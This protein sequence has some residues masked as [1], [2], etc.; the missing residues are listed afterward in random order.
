[1][2]EPIQIYHAEVLDHREVAPEHYVMTL[3]APQVAAQARPGQFV[4][5]R[6]LGGCDPLL[7][8]AYSVYHADTT[9]GSVEVLYRVVGRG[10]SRLRLN[11]R[12][13]RV[14]VWGPLG[15]AFTP[16]HG[17]RAVLVGGGV[18]IPPLAFWAHRLAALFPTI[19]RVALIGA[20]TREFLV[21]L[22]DFARAGAA[23]HTATDDG[24][25]GHAGFVT[26]LLPD[27]IAEEHTTVYA[28]GPMPMLAAVARIAEAR[29]VVAELA[30]EAPMAC[31]VGACLGCT[32]PRREGGY[33]RVC[34]DGP[35]FQASEIAW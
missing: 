29:G 12:G 1:M 4:M 28:C 20:A 16:P 2:A 22:E 31:G 30:L 24:S 13:G 27:W 6:S 25:A 32:V 18:G 10:T 23:L 26:E 19:E 15:S 33:A 34:T 8:R 7:P 35:V 14:H 5:V 17:A 11:E 21:G 9:R 3:A